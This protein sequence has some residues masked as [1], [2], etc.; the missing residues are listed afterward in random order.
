VRTFLS[1]I[2]AGSAAVIPAAA[3]AQEVDMAA[4]QRQLDTMQAEIER[5]RA[6]VAD[7]QAREDARAAAP[8]PASAP[9]PAP[10]A[11]APAEDAASIA[12]KG[13]PEISAPG[14][15]SFKPRDRL[16]V[17]TGAVDAPDAINDDSLGYATELRRAYL[18]VEG[19][20]PGGFG[21]RFEADLANS[22]VELTDFYLTYKAS[23]QL[24][25]I[26]GNQKPFWGLEEMQSDLFTSFMERAAFNSAF[27]FE[28]RVGL[29][30][31]YSSKDVLVQLGAFTDNPSDLNND[32][33]NSF[34]FDGR[35][36]FS[37]KVGDGQLHLGGSAHMRE[38]NDYASSVRYRARPFLHTTD[39]RLVDTGSFP[40]SGER[41]FGGELAYVQG[42]FHATV[43]AQ[44]L[45]AIRPGLANPTFWGGYAEVGMLLTPGDVM[46]YR[47]GVFDRVRPSSPVNKGG[48]G[49]L[50]LN[51]RYDRLDLNE[52]GIVG[53][54]QEVG[55]LS[56]IW[57]PTDYIRFLMNYGHLWISDAAIAAGV[58]RD[59][60]ADA[61]GMRA[62]IDF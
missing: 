62:Q 24:S 35:V 2:L 42:P 21:Y 3:H 27:G 39:V 9:A 1:L 6:Q 32:N 48:I 8:V 4:V 46:V 31:V 58:D 36:V 22:S 37:P 50:Q 41:S 15:W 57:M 51:V 33:N 26:L 11:P 40:A 29:G 23:Q 18:G 28:R 30:A 54:T 59:Y 16:Q 19:T 56:F 25:F 12:W 17:D 47:G 20:L 52:G 43:E 14:G 10:A 45:T 60:Q 38:L 61:F 44:A 13:A 49:A 34:G 55:G 53:G 5:L 7:M